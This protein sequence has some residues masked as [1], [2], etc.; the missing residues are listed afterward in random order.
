MGDITSFEQLRSQNPRFAQVKCC[1][2]RRI[3]NNNKV[4]TAGGGSDFWESGIMHPDLILEDL[5]AILHSHPTTE[6]LH[7]YRKIE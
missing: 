7:Y 3:Y 2:T 6:Q 1:R 5:H 4:L